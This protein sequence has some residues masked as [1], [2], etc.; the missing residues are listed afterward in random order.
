[1][2]LTESFC[3]YEGWYSCKNW[4]NLSRENRIQSTIT[5]KVSVCGGEWTLKNIF[6]KI[7]MFS[8]YFAFYM[9]YLFITN[10]KIKHIYN[11]DLNLVMYQDNPLLTLYQ[12]NKHLLSTSRTIFIS[13]DICWK[14]M[15]ALTLSHWQA[16][17][18]SKILVVKYAGSWL[19]HR[20]G[21]ISGYTHI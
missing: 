14:K 15:W 17:K 16:W 12:F 10:D 21:R 19:V 7:L 13:L 8:I 20:K 9:G 11:K 5:I 6:L 1:M 18:F 2:N 3:I 4:N